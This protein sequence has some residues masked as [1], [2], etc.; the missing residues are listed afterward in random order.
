V[1][2]T[3]DRSSFTSRFWQGAFDARPLSLFRIALG[4]A[5]L[6]D[7]ACQAAA[8]ATFYT[9]DGIFPRG[10]RSMPWMWSVFDLTG[11]RAG[12][13]FLFALGALVTL[14]FTVGLFT[15][16]ATALTFVFFVSLEHR[17]PEIHNGGDRMAAVLLFFGLFA[18]LSGRY[19]IDALRRGPR[20]DV[21]G[22]APRLLA[23]VPALLYAETAVEKLRD[24]GTGWFDGSVIFANL[25][26][27]GWTRAG[28]VW[29]GAHPSLC[30]VAGVATILLEIAVPV[31][32]FL[33]PSVKP[34]RA[35]AVLGY[36]AVQLGILFTLKVA[37][38]TN[39]MLA[40]TLLWLLPEWLDRLG[41]TLSAKGTGLA[42]EARHGWTPQMALTGGL[43]AAL[44]VAPLLPGTIGQLLPW[45][46]L[47]LNVGLF[48]WAYPSMRWEAKGELDDGRVIDP[49]PPEAN[50]TDRFANSLWMQLPYRLVDY[51]PLGRVVCRASNTGVG[52]RLRRWSVTKVIRPPYRAGEAPP[53]EKRRLVLDVTC[54]VP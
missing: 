3:P 19:S 35:L 32:F 31:L 29:L 16:F 21:Q 9:D 51:V 33:L 12:V 47:D 11:S 5:L 36:V 10:P 49:L 45:F 8:I 4:A 6:Q 39:V 17:V 14:A 1:A 25:H 54:P 53:D 40:A 41:G 22:F 30:T 26:I 2:A 7:L 37:M 46:G 38:F 50:F 15:R 52:P 13:A 20:A 42:V 27:V 24:A 44:V 18:D 28:G 48:A 34:A 23:A 43:F